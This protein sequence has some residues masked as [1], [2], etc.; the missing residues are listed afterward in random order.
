MTY[1][2]RLLFLCVALLAV[3]F[4]SDLS[5]Q[6]DQTRTLLTHADQSTVASGTARVIRVVDGDTI[7]VWW[8]DKNT[9]VRLIGVD[10]PETVDPRRPVE[11][12]GKEASRFASETLTGISVTL[13]G[14][15]SQ[16]EVDTYG[17]YLFYV[18]LPDGTLFNELLIREG[19]AREYTYQ[20]AYRSQHA[21]RDAE[22]D[23]RQAL[24]GLWAPDVCQAVQ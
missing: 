23:A 10:T 14:D 18:Y 6:D 1:T 7:D 17:R 24:L 19:F 20:T 21:F 8:N 16:G 22:A 12:Y 11:C 4:Q 5:L 15:A 3:L 13:V 9:R 2:L